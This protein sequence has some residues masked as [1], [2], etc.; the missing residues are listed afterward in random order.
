[1]SVIWALLVFNILTPGQAALLPIPHRIA[2]LMAQGALFIAL[3]L[4]VSINPRMRMRPNWFLGLYT[5]LAI[6][7]LM[8]SVRLVGIGTGYRSLRLIVFLLVLW[9]ITPW[10]G[11]RDLLILRSH[12]RVLLLILGS[13]V[14]GLCISPGRAMMANGRLADALWPIWPTGVAHFAGELA[15]LTVLLWLC[16]LVSRRHA[17]VVVVSAIAVL[18]LTHTRTAILATV[19]GLLVAGL[20]LFLGRRKVRR[21][22]AVGLLVV[23]VIGVPAAPLLV[24]W[25][26]RGENAQGL[27]TLT[28][29]TKAWS[30]VLEVHRPTT[31]VILGSGLSNDSVIGSSNPLS[32]GLSIDNSWLSTYQNQGLVGVVLL[33]TIFLLLLVTTLSRAQGPTRALALFLIVYCL[34]AGID[35]SALGG[36]S[37]Y[38]L[39]LAV[40]ASLI[41]SP[42]AIGT[43]LTF[44]PTPPERPQSLQIEG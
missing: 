12:V 37:P 40:V 5:I 42:S 43:D 27:S 34:I 22:F 24:H 39:D 35:E 30:A 7:A 21:T 32:N 2:Q 15:G 17:V 13:V 29:R 1:V 44:G 26:T 23:A 4:A 25:A 18:V 3:V 6:T 20:S 36:A 16:G 19:M 14:L 38:L 11:R 10:W 41:T 33:G 28:G 31:D 8:M 9:L